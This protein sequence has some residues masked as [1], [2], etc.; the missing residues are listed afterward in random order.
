[1]YKTDLISVCYSSTEQLSCAKVS[2]TSELI[3]S[4]LVI[5]I[6][7]T[8]HSL[9]FL[10]RLCGLDKVLVLLL[11]LTQMDANHVKGFNSFKKITYNLVNCG[12][13]VGAIVKVL[14]VKHACIIP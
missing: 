1:M 4:K 8:I 11:V 5:R 3:I 7:N 13:E 6:I 2:N 12:I 10:I 9:I 14:I